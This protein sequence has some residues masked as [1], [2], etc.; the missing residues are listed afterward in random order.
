[1]SKS[2]SILLL[3]MSWSSLAHARNY[4]CNRVEWVLENSWLPMPTYLA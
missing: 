1:M 3:L 2:K 4:N